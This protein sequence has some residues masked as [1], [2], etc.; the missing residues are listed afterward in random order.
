MI[1]YVS[2]R[3][4]DG[5]FCVFAG[6]NLRVLVNFDHFFFSGFVIDLFFLNGEIWEML[7]FVLV[8]IGGYHGFFFL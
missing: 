6:R 8:F 2:F 7:L 5:G 4:G 1:F 3:V